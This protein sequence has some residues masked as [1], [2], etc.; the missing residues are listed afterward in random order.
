L[1]Q[2]CWRVGPFF[3]LALGSAGNSLPPGVKR[4]G[5]TS[6]H[7]C[8]PWSQADAL[9]AMTE[10]FGLIYGFLPSLLLNAIWQP[11]P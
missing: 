10:E 9:D 5:Q 8:Q 3:G 1:P 11:L 7:N 2:W 6:E 4:P